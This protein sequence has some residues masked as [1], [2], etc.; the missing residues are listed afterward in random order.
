MRD[1]SDFMSWFVAQMLRLYTYCVG[2]LASIHFGGMTLLQIIVYTFVIGVALDIIVVS[3]RSR[4]V[5]DVSKDDK[6]NRKG[7]SNDNK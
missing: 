5:R 1:I 3:A 4:S 7:E 2:L 6:K